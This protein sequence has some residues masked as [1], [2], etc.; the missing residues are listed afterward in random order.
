MGAVYIIP[1]L[2]SLILSQLSAGFFVVGVWQGGYDS[3]S[4]PSQPAVTSRS[5]LFP[6]EPWI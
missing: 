4:Q 5:L 6:R 3:F 1:L 2:D